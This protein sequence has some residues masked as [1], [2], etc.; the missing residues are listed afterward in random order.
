MEGQL[1]K[2]PIG[3]VKCLVG[4]SEFLELLLN[5]KKDIRDMRQLALYKL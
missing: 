4:D 1:Q 3:D 5:V 2:Q